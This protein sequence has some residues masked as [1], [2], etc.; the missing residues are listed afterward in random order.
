M[1]PV[2]PPGGRDAREG[3]TPRSG[4]GFLLPA[5][6]TVDRLKLDSLGRSVLLSQ[7]ELP[8]AAAVRRIGR[9]GPQV[10]RQGPLDGL[11]QQV[12]AR[13]SLISSR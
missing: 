11:G 2:C 10:P 1:A 4:R 7:D 8:V 12:A 5:Q 13:P 6:L 9:R 3:C